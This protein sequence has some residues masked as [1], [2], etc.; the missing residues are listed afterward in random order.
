MAVSAPVAYQSYSGQSIGTTETSLTTNTSGPDLDT[1]FGNFALTLDKADLALGDEYVL[2]V[3]DK[4]VSG[5]T[6]R[7]VESFSVV[8]DARPMLKTVFFDL[9]YGWDIT[10]QKTAGTTRS[11]SWRITQV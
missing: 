5:G 6:Q 2:R 3:Y 1:T 4:A 8:A 9:A 11:F 10:L 7:L